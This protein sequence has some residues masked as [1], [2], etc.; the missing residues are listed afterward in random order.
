MIN[1]TEIR[2]NSKFTLDTLDTVLKAYPPGRYKLVFQDKWEC[3][4]RWNGREY[5]DIQ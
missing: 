2:V 3:K 4:V 1:L 5:T